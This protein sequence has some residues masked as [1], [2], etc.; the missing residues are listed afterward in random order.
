M[1]KNRV[2]LIDD[3]G[4]FRILVKQI[5]SEEYDVETA[6]DGSDA[7]QMLQSGYLPNLIVSDLMMPNVDGQTFVKQLMASAIFKKIP[8]II[9]SSVDKSSNRIELLKSGASDFMIKPFNPEELKVRIG[10]LLKNEA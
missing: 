4:E 1:K 3:K 6:I 10:N 9:L 7:L 2:L 5:L 8:V